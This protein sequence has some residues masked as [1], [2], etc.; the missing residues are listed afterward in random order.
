MRPMKGFE[1]VDVSS[2]HAWR[3]WLAAHHEQTE[4]IWRCTDKKHTGDRYLAYDDIVEDVLC[5]G[6]M[7]TVPRKLDKG[8]TMLLISSRKG[9]GLL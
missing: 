6:W 3:E 5:F 7:D 2:R 9:K 8:P 1:K 4:S